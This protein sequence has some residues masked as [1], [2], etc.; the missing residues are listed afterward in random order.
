M[1]KFL[2]GKK[3]LITSGPVWVPI[4]KVRIITSVFGGALG[5]VMAEKAREMGAEVLLLMGPGRAKIEEGENLQVVKF[6]YF[7]ELFELMKKEI[8]SKKYDIIIHS[9]AVP[10]YVPKKVFAGKIKSGKKDLVITMKPTIKIVDQVKK[11]DSSAVLVKFKLQVGCKEKELIKIAQKSMAASKADIMVANDLLDMAN[12][13]HIAFII[14][15]E[16]IKKVDTKDG[17]AEDLLSL[18]AKKI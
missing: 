3:I 7:D 9:A 12:N 6:K 17:L 8:S 2:E 4:D 13:K 1:E 18:A 11:W 10:D 15:K 14:D 16:G 5:V